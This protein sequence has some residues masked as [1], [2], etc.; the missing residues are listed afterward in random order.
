MKTLY[1]LVL[2]LITFSS[3]QSFYQAGLAG[4]EYQHLETPFNNTDTTTTA[5]YVKAGFQQGVEYYNNE[6]NDIQF[7]GY[8]YAV[9]RKYFG[10]AV[11]GNIF[12]GKYDVTSFVRDME[13]LNKSYDYWG[14]EAL[15]KFN[16]NIPMSSWCHWRIIGWQLTWNTERGAFYDFR[17]D[18]AKL[19]DEM[20]F[21]TSF[22]DEMTNLS[23]YVDSELLLN[24]ATD[25]FIGLNGAFG[26]NIKH[27]NFNF[28]ASSSIEYK[29]IGL[30]CLRKVGTPKLAHVYI[31]M[32][33]NTVKNEIYNWQFAVYYKF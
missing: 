15:I 10:F 5:H 7:L 12:H 11:G 27:M 13:H 31:S 20:E 1:I 19:D 8:H 16:F 6:K 2:V 14:A 4:S 30:K 22:M 28:V 18:M 32:F 33:D 26:T 21:G 24:P 25:L 29:S 17:D 3:C 9:S 23:F